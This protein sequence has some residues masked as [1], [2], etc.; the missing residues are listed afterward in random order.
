VRSASDESAEKNVV[1]ADVISELGIFGYALFGA[2][3]VEREVGWL[4]RTT[5]TE[6]NESDITVGFS[7]LDIVVL[8]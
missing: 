7:V 2:E 3:D 6:S 1:R 5:G 4:V 8:V